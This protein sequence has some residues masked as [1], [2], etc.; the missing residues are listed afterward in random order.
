LTLAQLSAPTLEALSASL[1]AAA[2]LHNPVD[3]LAS[4]TP[5]TY[6]ACLQLLLK[7]ENV[8]AVLTILPPPPMFSAD[9]VAKKIVKAMESDGLPSESG[10]PRDSK[11]P[12]VVALMGSDLIEKARTVF[13]HAHVPT[14]PFPER[15]ASAVGALVKRTEFLTTQ[16]QR[17]EDLIESTR[18]HNRSTDL[19]ELLNAYNIPLTPSKLARELHEAESIADELGYPVVMKI[20]SPDILHKSDVGGV[21]LNVQNRESLIRGYTQIFQRVRSAKPD[22]Q[23]DGVHI[24]HQ[25]PAGQ[26]VIVGAV[27]DPQFGPLIMFGSG[28]VEVEGLKDVSFALAPLTQ[29]EAL[30][31]I[32]RTWA[33]RKL[34]GFRNIPPADQESV[35][36][37]LIKLSH[38]VLEN[39]FIEEFEI[40]PLRVLAQGA[41][42]LDVRVKYSGERT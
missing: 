41:I 32:R 2:S 6:A 11:K 3:M 14:F 42:A 22:A 31:M 26:E 24:Q 5:A 27:R 8:D 15:A 7:D 23:I 16:T 33:G 29:A 36:D 9:D 30:N 17:R 4:A 18:I 13:E 10:E 1:P 12:V 40:N 39:E 38:L 35:I 21:I 19:D 25:I 34:A 37:V 20:A 28:G